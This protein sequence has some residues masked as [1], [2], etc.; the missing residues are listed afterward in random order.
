MLLLFAYWICSFSEVLLVENSKRLEV[1]QK[2]EG[3]FHVFIDWIGL[4]DSITS[5]IKDVTR[6]VLE[7]L[8]VFKILFMK[9]YPNHLVKYRGPS[10][11]CFGGFSLSYECPLNHPSTF[12]FNTFCCI[13]SITVLNHAKSSEWMKTCKPLCHALPSRVLLLSKAEVSFSI[14]LFFFSQ[15]YFIH[16][17]IHKKI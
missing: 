17:D 11:H 1:G 7:F 14:N 9:S 3:N 5:M 8:I 13:E 16:L 4:W 6:V 15:I 10:N 12:S 2:N